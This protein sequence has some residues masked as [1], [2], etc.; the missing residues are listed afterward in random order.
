[1]PTPAAVSPL[2]LLCGTA[3][4]EFRSLTS[5]TETPRTSYIYRVDLEI[6]H[7]TE[8]IISDTCEYKLHGFDGR[9]CLICKVC[10][11]RDITIRVLRAKGHA[12]PARTA[13]RP[14]S[15]GERGERVPQ[16]V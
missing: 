7:R 14:S 9:C 10:L 13:A 5:G 6:T 11:H 16:R 12:L 1:M 15:D 8:I 4:D 2:D 3:V